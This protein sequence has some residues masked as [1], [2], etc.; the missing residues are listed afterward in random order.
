MVRQKEARRRLV[1]FHFGVVPLG[2]RQALLVIQVG[3]RL[4]LD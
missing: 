2:H 3:V 4:G 1:P